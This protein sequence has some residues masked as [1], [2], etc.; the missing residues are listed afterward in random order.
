[1]R[2]CTLIHIVS[3]YT[4]TTNDEKSFFW[5]LARNE[6]HALDVSVEITRPVV[7]VSGYGRDFIS[8]RSGI[9]RLGVVA[10]E[11]CW[12]FADEDVAVCFICHA[13]FYLAA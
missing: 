5:C 7:G 10:P 13:A 11:T 3:R 12:F 6:S 2:R 9:C 1:M 4:L 8:G